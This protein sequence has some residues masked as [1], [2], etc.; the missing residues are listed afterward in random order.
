M[1]F[2]LDGTGRIREDLKLPR[3][4]FTTTSYS[5]N[6]AAAAAPFVLK[7]ENR[8]GGGNVDVFDF[9]ANGIEFRSGLD[10]QSIS[11]YDEE[12]SPFH[13]E[14]NFLRRLKEVGLYGH[15]VAEMLNQS[16]PGL[17]SII[18]KDAAQKATQY[19]WDTTMKGCGDDIKLAAGEAI[20]VLNGLVGGTRHFQD[21]P[22]ISD[23]F[24]M[25]LR[26]MYSHPDA[27]LLQDLASVMGYMQSK[28]DQS[29]V[30]YPR[31]IATLDH[32]PSKMPLVWFFFSIDHVDDTVY[33]KRG[34]LR[35]HGW[36]K[37]LVGM[38]QVGTYKELGVVALSLLTEV[39]SAMLDMPI[40]VIFLESLVST[41]IVIRKMR[42]TCGIEIP[43][44][45]TFSIYDEE[46]L[47]VLNVYDPDAIFV[48]EGF[49]KC[50]K[51]FT[52]SHHPSP[53]DRNKRH[54]VGASCA[55]CKIAGVQLYSN[56]GVVE[57]G[58]FCSEHCFDVKQ[59]FL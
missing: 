48:H 7:R 16:E 29:D 14:T 27:N 34:F 54:R 9:H 45:S 32:A 21:P 25:Q 11:V 57:R 17:W 36:T 56:E 51:M 37:S 10:L 30:S 55:T 38:A 47:D 23:E 39:A 58:L 5:K 26:R 1:G 50:W 40:E 20:V 19:Y 53:P 59:F 15:N 41:D 2:V 43:L 4:D 46:T 52:S 22:K 6:P 13:I 42:N 49:R 28:L 12:R 35:L 18:G 31:Y 33:G 24:L 44:V 3:D 8:I